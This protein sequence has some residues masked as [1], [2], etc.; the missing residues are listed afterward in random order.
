MSPGPPP[1]KG[2]EQQAKTA[3]EGRKTISLSPCNNNPP[4]YSHCLHWAIAQK[5]AAR[6]KCKKS[7]GGRL[8]RRTLLIK[9]I[10]LLVDPEQSQ[11]MYCFRPSTQC[12]KD[13]SETSLVLDQNK[14]MPIGRDR[15]HPSKLLSE[16]YRHLLQSCT[17]A[18][19]RLPNRYGAIARL[20]SL[21]QGSSPFLRPHLEH[22]NGKDE[23][24]GLLLELVEVCITQRLMLVHLSNATAMVLSLQWILPSCNVP[25]AL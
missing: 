25:Q 9:S 24:L 1:T 18:Q 22:L 10:Q 7:N 13:L 21:S 14:K 19:E 15:Q 12:H 8:T 20:V 6:L 16:G 4:A 3:R 2:Q 17:Q 11:T 23:G 5:R